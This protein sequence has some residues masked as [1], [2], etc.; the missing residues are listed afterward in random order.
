[1]QVRGKGGSAPPAGS[2][3]GAAWLAVLGVHVGR[4]PLWKLWCGHVVQGD[5]PSF[6]HRPY[7]EPVGSFYQLVLIF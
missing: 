1:M 4:S 5:P 6:Q 2:A 7:R 3:A